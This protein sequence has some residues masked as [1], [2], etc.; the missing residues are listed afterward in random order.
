MSSL[1]AILAQV[2]AFSMSDVLAPY[3]YVFY[4]SFLVALVFTPLMRHVAIHYGLAIF[5]GLMGVLIVYVR[6]RFAGAIYLMIFGFIV[7][8]AYKMGMVHEK[9]APHVGT[10]LHGEGAEQEREL[11]N[12][13]TR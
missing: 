11:E 4:T 6:T 8:A 10:P 3:I 9:A 1:A 7:V 12:A 5:F 13:A 2:T